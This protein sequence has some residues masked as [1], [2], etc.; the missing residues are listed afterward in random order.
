M[1]V[2]PAPASVVSNKLI[3]VVYPGMKEFREDIGQYR[4]VITTVENKH[5]TRTFYVVQND[6]IAFAYD[7]IEGIG[8][9]GIHRKIEKDLWDKYPQCCRNEMCEFV[10]GPAVCECSWTKIKGSET[11]IFEELERRFLDKLDQNHD[12]R[13]T[14]LL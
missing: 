10:G 7:E 13:A 9:L 2:G 1:P 6:E 12:I 8:G 5:G 4:H 14:R 3:T 11:E